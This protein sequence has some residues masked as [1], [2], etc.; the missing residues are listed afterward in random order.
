[1][2]VGARSETIEVVAG[3]AMVQ[4]ETAGHC[5]VETAVYLQ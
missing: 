5:A 3:V 2:A 4:T 1:M